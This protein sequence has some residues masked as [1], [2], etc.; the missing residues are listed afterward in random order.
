MAT[1]HACPGHRYTGIYAEVDVSGPSATV[2]ILGEEIYTTEIDEEVW[3]GYEYVPATESQME[4]QAL[5]PLIE[6]LRHIV[7]PYVHH[8][9]LD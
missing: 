5:A 3:D 4:K 1:S 6:G 8:P 2:S 9:F 7:K